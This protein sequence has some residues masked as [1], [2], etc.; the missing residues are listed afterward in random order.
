M[1]LDPNAR[2]A[3]WPQRP[4]PQPRMPSSSP[5]LPPWPFAGS[6]LGDRLRCGRE[7][8]GPAE[9]CFRPPTSLTT[10]L[11]CPRLWENLHYAGHGP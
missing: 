4:H 9:P 3:L 5:P 6:G 2:R 11:F 7:S 1:W 10:T 8:P